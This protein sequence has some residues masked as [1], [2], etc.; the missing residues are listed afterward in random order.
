[1]KL[2]SAVPGSNVSCHIESTMLFPTHGVPMQINPA[3]GEFAAV[4]I[5]GNVHELVDF[6]EI[7]DFTIQAASADDG[8]EM[9]SIVPRRPR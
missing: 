4:P 5:T 8:A 3:D 1:M 6:D 9:P 7:P 2:F